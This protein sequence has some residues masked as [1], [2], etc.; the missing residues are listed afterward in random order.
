MAW[1]IACRSSD[2]GDSQERLSL[3]GP[4]LSIDSTFGKSATGADSQFLY[5]NVLPA[6]FGTF[7]P[8]ETPVDLNGNAPFT[9][10]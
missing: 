1:P 3:V 5:P 9:S 8:T 6:A 2:R 7:G 10:Q 4:T